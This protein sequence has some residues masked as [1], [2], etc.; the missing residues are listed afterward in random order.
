[1][2]NWTFTLLALAFV[3]KA[4]SIIVRK[5]LRA[6]LT[7]MDDIPTLGVL[8]GKDL[9]ISGTA[10]VCGGRY[11]TLYPCVKKR[12]QYLCIAALRGYLVLECALIILRV[13][14]WSNQK[15]RSQRMRG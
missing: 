9:R 15:N 11:V 3:Y 4:I 2:F 8:R 7:A 12:L 13:S 5:Y 6:T 10:V 1:M 14:L